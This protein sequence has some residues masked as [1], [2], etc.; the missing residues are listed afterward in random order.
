MR[1]QV[2]YDDTV[3][4]L[5]GR[6]SNKAPSKRHPGRRRRPRILTELKAPI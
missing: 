4:P 5:G 6:G 3:Q 1:F 2:R